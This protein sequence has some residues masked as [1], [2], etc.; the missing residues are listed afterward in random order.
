MW[1]FV[2]HNIR[3]TILYAFDIHYHDKCPNIVYSFTITKIVCQCG[4]DKEGCSL[5]FK[6]NVKECR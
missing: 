6:D 3:Q 4:S 5:M 2:V 1:H